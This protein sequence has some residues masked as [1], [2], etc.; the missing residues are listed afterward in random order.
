MYKKKYIAP[1]IEIHQTLACY[2]L[3]SLSTGEDD[4]ERGAQG[5]NDYDF[6]EDDDDIKTLNLWSF[7]Q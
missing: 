1:T 3:A 6:D 5:A 2:T 7:E 4:D